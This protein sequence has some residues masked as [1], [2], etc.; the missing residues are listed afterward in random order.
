MNYPFL[1]ET[2]HTPAVTQ[3]SGE[4]EGVNSHMVE[5]ELMWGWAPLA[6]VSCFVLLGLLLHDPAW[7]QHWCS[8]G[9]SGIMGPFL[10]LAGGGDGWQRV[11]GAS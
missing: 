3:I 4:N 2:R 7:H 5:V 8:H 1:L 6:G 10:A 9:A 11:A